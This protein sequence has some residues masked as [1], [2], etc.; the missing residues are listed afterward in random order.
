MTPTKA[1]AAA[2][3]A[4]KGAAQSA[5]RLAK[6]PPVAARI[7]ELSK[8]LS[9]IA[10]Q[11]AVI[12]RDFVLTGLKEIATN[13]EEKCTSAR[14]RAYELLGQELGMFRDA[15]DHTMKWDGDPAKLTKEQLETLTK[16][17]ENKVFGDDEKA[18][19]AAREEAIRNMRVQ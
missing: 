6:S 10:V 16:A 4:G 7:E 8:D 14:V 11:R 9:C 18:A 19:A 5:S 3:F 13:N 12:D 15:I 17:I 1:Y 2:G